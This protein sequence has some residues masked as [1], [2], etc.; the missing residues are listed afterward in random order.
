M[1]FITAKTCQFA[2]QLSLHNCNQKIKANYESEVFVLSYFKTASFSR[3]ARYY[4]KK[5]PNWVLVMKLYAIYEPKSFAHFSS[6]AERG[7]RLLIWQL[8]SLFSIAK[9]CSSCHGFWAT[10]TAHLCKV[11]T[12]HSRRGR[13]FVGKLAATI[14]LGKQFCH[15]TKHPL[16]LIVFC[17]WARNGFSSDLMH[18]RRKSCYTSNHVG[19][20][21]TYL[22]NLKAWQQLHSFGNGCKM[23][24]PY[25]G[26][27][28]K[29]DSL[30]TS[31]AP[32][33]LS[34]AGNATSTQAKQ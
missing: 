11:K 28:D 10:Q 21:R 18:I 13:V 26:C 16:C 29:K 7:K 14:L 4:S 17:S 30:D 23:Y 19:I 31:V 33:I 24:G 1:S 25:I 8:A 2:N 6:F 9:S 32:S 27:T 20:L 15:R 12:I 5:L 3:V 34:I 22:P